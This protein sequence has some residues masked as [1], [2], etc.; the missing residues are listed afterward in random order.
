MLVVLD[1]PDSRQMS[2]QGNRHLNTQCIRPAPIPSDLRGSCGKAAEATGG[3]CE[4]EFP[5]SRRH[6]VLFGRGAVG[7]GNQR[8]LSVQAFKQW[9]A[10]VLY[11]GVSKLDWF[12]MLNFI[13]F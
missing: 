4:A 5:I 3:Q 8:A 10:L 12:S 6:R 2:G 9:L 13:A 1:H 11:R 7:V